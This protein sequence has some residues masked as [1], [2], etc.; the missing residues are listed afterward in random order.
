MLYFSKFTEKSLKESI[1][2][3]INRKIGTN[4]EKILLLK[5]CITIKE[6]LS[7]TIK[8][9]KG[10]NVNKVAEDFC[11]AHKINP[12]KL[13]AITMYIDSQVKAALQK[14][15]RPFTSVF[16]TTQVPENEK[17]TKRKSIS[18]ASSDKGTI[19]TTTNEGDIKKPHKKGVA[20]EISLGKG[21]SDVIKVREEE[22]LR[23]VAENFVKVLIHTSFIYIYISF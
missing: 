19:N 16:E 7:D 4:E 20:L 23:V 17:S 11:K 1:N 2:D 21:K 14:Q 22:N 10:D 13:P 12:S 5:L 9:Y 6:G 18:N 8:I 15:S 3:S